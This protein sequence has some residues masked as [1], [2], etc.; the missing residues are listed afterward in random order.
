MNDTAAIGRIFYL[1]RLGYLP[2]NKEG[3]SSERE[4]DEAVAGKRPR[5]TPRWKDVPRARSS[6]NT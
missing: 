6:A 2:E 4:Q 3:V 1:I 5:R